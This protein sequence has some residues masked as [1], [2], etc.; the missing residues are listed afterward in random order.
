VWC[1]EA[2]FP[3]ALAVKGLLA[4]WDEKIDEVEIAPSS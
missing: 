3:E 4:F 1:Y 2:P